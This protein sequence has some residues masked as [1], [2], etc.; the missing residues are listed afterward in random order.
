MAMA[1]DIAKET[2]FKSIAVVI[3]PLTSLMQDHVKFLKSIAAEFIAEDQNDEGGD[4][5]IVFGLIDL[6][7]GSFLQVLGFTVISPHG[8]I[9]PSQ[10]APTKVRSLHNR[11][12]FAPYVKLDKF[13]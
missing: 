12:Y 8:Q 11:S 10:I 3:S 7:L 5:Q 2:T 4:C 9:A 6:L 13:C 1:I